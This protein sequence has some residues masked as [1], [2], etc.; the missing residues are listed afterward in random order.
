MTLLSFE[1]DDFPFVA[2]ADPTAVGH[3]ELPFK[4]VT[5]GWG[6]VGV[7]CQAIPSDQVGYRF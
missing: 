6:G 3:L 2:C 4:V 5:E 7:E 1:E